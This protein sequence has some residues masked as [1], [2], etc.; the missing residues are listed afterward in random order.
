MKPVYGYLR[1]SGK[2]QLD[3]DG[4]PRQREAIE[5]WCKSNNARVIRWF[6][7]EGVSGTVDSMERPAYGQMLKHCGPATAMTIVAESASRLARDLMVSEL[8]VQEAKRLG[9]EIYEAVSGMELSQSDDPTRVMIRQMLGVVSQWQKTMLVRQMR[10]ARDRKRRETG[11]CEGVLS[12]M[13]KAELPNLERNLRF[14]LAHKFSVE[15]TR[16]YLNEGRI[17]TPTGK[18]YW[19]WRSTANALEQVKKFDCRRAP[20]KTA[21]VPASA[22]ILF[23]V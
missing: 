16:V 17:P 14:A 8:L 1:V 2:G 15:Q 12:W 23:P 6:Q 10:A 4:F 7:E 13:D 21:E 20:T 3:G 5:R 9:V 11:R 18:R 19:T 22:E